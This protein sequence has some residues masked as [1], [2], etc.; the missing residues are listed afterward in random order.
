[1]N[2]DRVRKR[3]LRLKRHIATLKSAGSDTASF[4]AELS[5]LITG[6]RKPS[7]TIV[8]PEV[9]SRSVRVGK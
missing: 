6:K 7:G 9:V 3:V 1:M 8:T 5:A 4:E 2:R